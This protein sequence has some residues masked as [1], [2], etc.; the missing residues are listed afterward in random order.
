MK[1]EH[2]A[3]QDRLRFYKDEI[4][5]FNHHLGRL[6]IAGGRG[7]N[8]AAAEHFQNQFVR[9]KEVLDTIRHD[10]KQHENLIDA[11]GEDASREPSEG[12]QRVHAI[13]RDK[14]EQFER[15]F[16]DL[17]NEFNVFLNKVEESSEKYQ[18]G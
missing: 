14:L 10:F 11:I 9:Q 17:R 1:N 15:I 5:H 4:L 7:E 6:A 2:D 3:W 13:Q 8:M 18:H 16:H 12:I